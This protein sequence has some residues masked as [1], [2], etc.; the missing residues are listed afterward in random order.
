MN[1][2]EDIDL[3]SL[4]GHVND[5]IAKIWDGWIRRCVGEILLNI[6]DHH[7]IEAEDW[8]LRP[9]KPTKAMVFC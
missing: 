1:G 6:D 7:M 5:N 4:Y 2:D 9:S 3:E 8:I